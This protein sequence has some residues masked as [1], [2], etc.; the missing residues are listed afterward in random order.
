MAGHADAVHHTR[1]EA[2]SVFPA[3][4][5]GRPLTGDPDPSTARAAAC[6]AEWVGLPGIAQAL[7]TH[8]GVPL[9]ERCHELSDAVTV[10]RP[11]LAAGGS[12]RSQN[13]RFR[14]IYQRDGNLVLY[15][16]ETRTPRWATGT[17]GTDP[18][19]AVLHDSGDFVVYDAHGQPRWST[20]TTGHE[21]AVLVLQ[22]D[23]NVVLRGSSDS[24]LWACCP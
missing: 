10:L 7:R 11:V 18:G 3:I 8:A 16:D 13:V 6:T 5:S 24:R 15:D 17:Q 23:G 22:D 9:P 14:L 2:V 20:Q 19:H 12:I 4:L 1:L 21:H